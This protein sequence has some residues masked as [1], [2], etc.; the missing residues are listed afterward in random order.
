MSKSKILII[1]PGLQHSHQLAWAL[2]QE[3]LLKEFW[4]GVPVRTFGSEKPLWISRKVW[5]RMREV[6]IP[7]ENMRSHP[8]WWLLMRAA[9]NIGDRALRFRNMHRALYTIDYL[10]ASRI[11]EKKPTM[12]IAYENAALHTFQAAKS[13]GAKCVLDAASFHFQRGNE[14]LAS[15]DPT[16]QP[17][18]DERKQ[19]EIELAD[20][21]ICCSEL[22]RD[23]Y[24]RAGVRPDKVLAMPLGATLPLNSKNIVHQKNENSPLK[25]IYAGAMHTRKSIDLI[26]DVMEHLN[27]ERPGEVE[28]HIYGGSDSIEW[29]ARAQAICNVKFHGPVAQF[30]LFEELAGAD[31]LLLPSR[32]D[33]FGMVVAESMA[34]GTPVIVSNQT[35]AKSIIEDHPGAGWIIAADVPSIKSAILNL[36]DFPNKIIDARE[37]AKIASQQYTWEKYRERVGIAIGGLL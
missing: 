30:L 11:P 9:M 29:V 6:E 24:V 34:V 16:F 10:V 37:V 25:L 19:R 18:I 1:Q 35:G 12:V 14:L 7:T 27:V 36:I 28:L 15:T 26:F 20:S 23:S 3:G 13:V 21:I 31:A 4:S 17:K 5:Q 33:S 8:Q 2:H 32:F 22:A